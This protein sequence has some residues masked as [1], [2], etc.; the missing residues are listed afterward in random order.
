MGDWQRELSVTSEKPDSID[1]PPQ[2]LSE[3]ERMAAFEQV[4]EQAREALSKMATEDMVLPEGGTPE[5]P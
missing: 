2:D 4:Y 3:D 5:I 1:F